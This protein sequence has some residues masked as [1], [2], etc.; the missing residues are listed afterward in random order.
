MGLA[1]GRETWSKISNCT[2]FYCTYNDYNW[3]W[4]LQAMGRK[5][6]PGFLTTMVMKGSRVFHVG[7]W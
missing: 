4:T 1:F 5:C 2:K 3:D 7:K 6:I